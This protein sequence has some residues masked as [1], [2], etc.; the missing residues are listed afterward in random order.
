[1]DYPLH[2][3]DVHISDPFI[4]ADPV[5]GKYYLY[6]A[7]F[8]LDRFPEQ[9]RRG[10]FH[11][12]V[13]EDLVHWSAPIRVFDAQSTGFWADLDYWAPECHIWQGK[14]YIASTFRAEGMYRRC[15][16]L[17]ADNPLGPFRPI[18]AEPVTPP[19]WQCLDGTLYV[20][21]KGKPWMVYCHEWLQVYDGQ[22][23]AIPL[24]DDL[25]HAI[26]DPIVLFRGSDAPWGARLAGQDRFNGFVTDGPFLHRLPDGKLI[27]LWT[28]F[29]R[30]GY[31]TGYAVSRSGEI[32]GPWVQREDPLYG[33]DG[34]H[35]MLFY[36]LP[37]HNSTGGQ[38]MMALHC[39]NDHP[40]KRMLLFEM[41]ER[42][43]ELRIIN[44]CTGNWFTGVGGK[45]NFR[46]FRETLRE[47]PVFSALTPSTHP[48]GM[49]P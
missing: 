47:E 45:A 7:F 9:Q 30:E 34:G 38:L 25:G 42:G 20:D 13:S 43:G 12:L 3:R 33:L 32:F 26:G 40:K 41:D 46:G 22:V 17:V 27:M 4:L 44:E 24:S 11:A 10:A 48:K 49:I 6:A 8:N 2:V 36:T 39:P 19:G 16:F 14:Y 5:S 37:G 23:C 29:S 28:N 1:M 21:R 31:A 15:Q 18:E 35:S